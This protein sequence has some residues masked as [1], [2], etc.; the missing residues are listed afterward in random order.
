MD[1]LI[2]RQAVLDLAKDLKFDNGYRHRCIDP[3]NVRELPSVIPAFTWIPISEMCPKKNGYYL[4][5]TIYKQ[6][7]CDYWTDDRFD[8]TE[9]VIAWMPLPRPFK[10]GETT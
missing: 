2:S 6:V 5:T 1:D 4:T 3:D 9:T 10:E 7:Y 8:R